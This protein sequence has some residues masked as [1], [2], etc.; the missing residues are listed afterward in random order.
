MLVC[1]LR[2]DDICEEGV[3]E[4]DRKTCWQGRSGD[5]AGEE[6]NLNTKFDGAVKGTK[7]RC[8]DMMKDV[9]VIS[10]MQTVFDCGEER[11]RFAFVI[12]PAR[13]LCNGVFGSR[14]KRWL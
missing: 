8:A 12:S 4:K 3:D 6:A 9:G 11:R 13:H 10:P 14:Q 2:F 7:T 1:I 5:V